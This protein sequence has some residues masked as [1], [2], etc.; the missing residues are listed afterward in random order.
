MFHWHE[1][2]DGLFCFVLDAGS[3]MRRQSPQIEETYCMCFHT[4]MAVRP[5]LLFRLDVEPVSVLVI[6]QYFGDIVATYVV[7]LMVPNLT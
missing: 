6:L 5:L 7:D 4:S 2:M 3:P 1:D